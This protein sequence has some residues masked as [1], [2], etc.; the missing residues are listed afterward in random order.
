MAAGTR[1]GEEVRARA[2]GTVV[3]PFPHL[4]GRDSPPRAS[5]S[6][7]G[8][9]YVRVPRGTVLGPESPCLS[10]L[11]QPDPPLSPPPQDSR[12]KPKPR[13]AL[14]PPAL[15]RAHPHASP[16]RYHL[17]RPVD[18]PDSAPCQSR[19]YPSETNAMDRPMPGHRGTLSA[20]IRRR[21]PWGQGHI[22]LGP[23]I[24]ALI[25][26]GAPPLV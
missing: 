8:F 26:S 12:G 11:A 16:A 14:A 25:N 20:Q 5:S 17:D 4:G 24:A 18:R 23:A 9:A 22:P 19:S 7:Q 15:L 6:S 1:A 13:P 3:G 10:G 21:A 2:D